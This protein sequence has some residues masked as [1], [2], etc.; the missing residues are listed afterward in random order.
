MEE[1]AKYQT[2]MNGAM[3]DAVNDEVMDALNDV[4]HLANVFAPKT[5]DEQKILNT[6]LRLALRTGALPFRF[7]DDQEKHYRKIIYSTGI[8]VGKK[9]TANKDGNVWTVREVER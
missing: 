9:F 8:E 3:T 1:Q 7:I 5:R 4:I 6:R 2:K